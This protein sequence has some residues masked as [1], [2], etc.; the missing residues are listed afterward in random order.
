MI[1]RVNGEVV[2]VHSHHC[3]VVEDVPLLCLRVDEAT[4]IEG[5]CELLITQIL[6]LETVLA[7]SWR[8]ERGSACP[9]RCM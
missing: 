6:L 8:P 1:A 4:I 3:A 7:S 9:S 5:V 2:F